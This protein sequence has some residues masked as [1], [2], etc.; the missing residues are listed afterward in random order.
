MRRHRPAQE[1]AFNESV[2]IFLN[3]NQR[4]KISGVHRSRE[5]ALGRGNRELG[6]WRCGGIAVRRRS[7][8]STA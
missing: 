7:C 3:M 2:N 1:V 6:G 4:R 8:S 5:R